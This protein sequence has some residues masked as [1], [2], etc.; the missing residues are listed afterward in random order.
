MKGS[1]YLVS[2]KKLLEGFIYKYLKLYICNI[3]L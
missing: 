3:I 2:N 1:Q